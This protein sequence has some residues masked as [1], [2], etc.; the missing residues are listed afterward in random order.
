VKYVPA[1]TGVAIALAAL[2]WGLDGV[3]AAN[4]ARVVAVS[5]GIAFLASALVSFVN[6]WRK[7]ARDAKRKAVL[8][9]M[10]PRTEILCV[11]N[12]P[13]AKG[14]LVRFD[15]ATGTVRRVETA[16]YPPGPIQ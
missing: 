16:S 10:V 11:A 9:A 6:G 7:A 5:F 12:G 4:A 13:I 1:I 2:L 15:L 14:E 8:A 3:T